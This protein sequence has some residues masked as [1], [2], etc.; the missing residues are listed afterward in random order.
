MQKAHEVADLIKPYVVRWI[1]EATVIRGSKSASSGE[2]SGGGALPATIS[3]QTG[4][5]TTGA[6][7][8]HQVDAVSSVLTPTE[9][10][11]K[12]SA[13]GYLNVIRLGVNRVPE[14]SI[15]A[16]GGL[17]VR[18]NEIVGSGSGVR[19]GYLDFSNTGYLESRAWS[20]SVGVE[21]KNLDIL[22][23]NIHLRADGH[24][25]NGIYITTCGVS[26]YIGIND[27]DTKHKRINAQ[28]AGHEQRNTIYQ[29]QLRS[30]RYD[31][32]CRN[33]YIRLAYKSRWCNRGDKLN[34][35]NSR[36]NW[37]N[38]TWYK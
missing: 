20:A 14:M 12:T 11:L 1:N 25:T 10:L 19:L 8:T 17:F 27:K 29:I 15:D 2:V 33:Q 24:G 34:W 16:C 26:G 13:S 31:G 35:L 22:G 3:A 36:F 28:S 4:N 9:K 30:T 38:V 37:T 32:N 18:G 23:G 5:T 21:Y 6:R 7:H